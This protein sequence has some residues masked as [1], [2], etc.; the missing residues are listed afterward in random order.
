MSYFV[1]IA[2]GMADCLPNAQTYV[3][4]SSKR[5]LARAVAEA[6]RAFDR[7]EEARPYRYAFRAPASPAVTNWSQRVRIARHDDR[8]L[9]V[10]GMTESDWLEQEGGE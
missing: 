10:I 5:A 6:C 3:Q 7:E 8:V 9:D 2:D 1:C 4:A